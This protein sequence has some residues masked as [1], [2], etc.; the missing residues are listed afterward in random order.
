[1]TKPAAILLREK[2]LEYEREARK[3]AGFAESREKDAAGYRATEAR[4]RA[5]SKDAEAAADD[6]EALE[7]RRALYGGRDPVT[8]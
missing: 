2:S 5:L 8:G 3:Y 1:M 4:L 6:L 7:K